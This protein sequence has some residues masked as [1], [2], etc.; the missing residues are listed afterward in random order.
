[1]HLAQP[2]LPRRNRMSTGERRLRP[3]TLEIILSVATSRPYLLCTFALLLSMPREKPWNTV[4]GNASG[5]N[6]G[7]VETH[8]CLQFNRSAKNI[9][10]EILPTRSGVPHHDVSSHH[11]DDVR[12]NTR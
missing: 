9:R 4:E 7:P 11:G 3:S 6:R 1:M 2:P 12:V 10:W 8:T 5:M